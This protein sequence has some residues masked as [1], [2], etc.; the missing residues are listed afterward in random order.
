MSRPYLRKNIERIFQFLELTNVRIEITLV[1]DR[2]MRRVN[3]KFMKQKGTTDVLSFPH[4]NPLGDFKNYH[5][6]FLGDIM[7]SLDQAQRQAV[8]Q[9]LSLRK[10]VLFLIVH[11]ILHLLG[12]DHATANERYDMQGHESR[13]WKHLIKLGI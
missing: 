13:I 12:H 10:E 3:A 9:K 2:T 11:S 4:Q 7:V 1:D 6:K 8:K 5:G